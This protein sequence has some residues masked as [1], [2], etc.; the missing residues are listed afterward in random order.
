M[1]LRTYAI[2]AA[3]PSRP[4]AGPP[5]A[6][7]PNEAH[8]IQEPGPRVG[9]GAQPLCPQL[10]VRDGRTHR[11]AVL[12]RRRGLGRRRRLQRHQLL[13]ERGAHRAKRLVRLLQAMHRVRR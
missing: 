4:G 13:L 2:R 6:Q 11:R 1:S 10:R 8:Q 5:S 12:G 3:A 7:P 9:Q